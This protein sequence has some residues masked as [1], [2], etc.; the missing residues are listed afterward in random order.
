VFERTDS[1]DVGFVPILPDWLPPE[2]PSAG[3]AW[4]GWKLRAK[5]WYILEKRPLVKRKQR[6]TRA[7]QKLSDRVFEW[8]REDPAFYRRL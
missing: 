3:V 8:I 2:P 7:N 1:T 5:F 6:V 4:V